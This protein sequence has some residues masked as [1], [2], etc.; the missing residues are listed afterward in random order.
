[1]VSDQ[2]R[3]WQ[4]ELR[5][6]RTQPAYLLRHFESAELFASTAAAAERA[7]AVLWR[8]DDQ[9]AVVVAPH[10]YEG[11]KAHIRQAKQAL[12]L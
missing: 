7:G 12:G 5:R 4:Q 3:L 6:L 1:M 2:I 10:A 11:L 8:S 9:R